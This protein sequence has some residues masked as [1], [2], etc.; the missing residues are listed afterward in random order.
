MGFADFVATATSS[1]EANIR[2][3]LCIL[4]LNTTFTIHIRRALVEKKKSVTF[5]YLRTVLPN[6]S[7]M[8]LIYFYIIK[9]TAIS[10]HSYRL[11]WV[12]KSSSFLIFTRKIICLEWEGQAENQI[13]V[14]QQKGCNYYQSRMKSR[15]RLQVKYSQ[16]LSSFQNGSRINEILAQI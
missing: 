9:C 12:T 15:S 11:P 13:T 16:L 1:A 14:H 8:L 4:N 3:E 7:T 5:Y 2:N 6:F 10:K